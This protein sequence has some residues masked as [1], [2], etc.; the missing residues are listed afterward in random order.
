MAPRARHLIRSWKFFQFWSLIWLQSYLHHGEIRIYYF[1]KRNIISF[2]ETH[3]LKREFHRS[4]KDR[5]TLSKFFGENFSFCTEITP[6]LLALAT[7]GDA[8]QIAGNPYWSGRLCT[9][10]LLELIS[11]DQLLLI[12]QILLTFYIKQ[13]TLL[14]GQL[15]FPGKFPCQ[16]LFLANSVISIC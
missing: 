13:G 11:L 6:P 1:F 15:Y 7:L 9:G 8:K 2:L 14:G 16:L 4:V 10:G 5:F 3:Q 12:L